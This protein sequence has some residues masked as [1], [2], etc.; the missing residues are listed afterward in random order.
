VEHSD[1]SR[2][3]GRDSHFHRWESRQFEALANDLLDGL[4]PREYAACVS[5]WASQGESGQWLTRTD[6]REL[7]DEHRADPCVVLPVFGYAR[8]ALTNS[9]GVVVGPGSPMDLLDHR[10]RIAVYFDPMAPGAVS[11]LYLLREAFG[12]PNHKIAFH[13]EKITETEH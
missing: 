10:S 3:N 7:C 1:S 11:A 4:R 9:L 8:I 12:I 5:A 2:D 13:G 6:L